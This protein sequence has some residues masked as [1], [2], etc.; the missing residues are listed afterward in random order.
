[1]KKG[2][3][4]SLI[5][6]IFLCGC[7]KIPKLKNGEEAIVTFKKGDVDYKISAEDLFEE[8]KTN[9][10]LEATVKMIDTFILETEFKD[11]IDSNKEMAKNYIKA[12]TEAYG[13]EEDLLDAIRENTNYS[14]IEAYQEYLYLSFMQSTAS[15]EYAKTLVTDKEINNYY[16]NDVQGDIEL[17]HI[18]ITPKVT[19]DMSDED[20][21]AAEES[22][23]TLA[24]DIIKKLDEAEDKLETFKELAKEYSDDEA[25]K[26]I[27]GNLGYVNYGD[28]NNNYE[29]LLYVAYNLKDGEYSKDYLVTELGYHIVLRNKT[30]EKDKLEDIKDDIIDK[31]ASK[32]MQEDSTISLNSMK[33]YRK[34]YNVNITDSKLDRQYGIYLNNL[35]N[36]E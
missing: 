24:S 10:G 14:S 31:L 17:F 22:A 27:G 33:Y 3:I 4:L 11:K 35:A 34:L 1:M 7:G 8:L 16:E 2:I 6:L 30:K 9:F 26:E 36:K 23:K 20:K 19:D 5:C 18:L 12:M 13:S 21:T 15:E 25:T 29:T 28:L 32:K